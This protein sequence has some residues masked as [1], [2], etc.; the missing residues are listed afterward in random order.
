MHWSNS[1][2]II[3]RAVLS[4]Q[5]AEAHDFKTHSTLSSPIDL[6]MSN[7]HRMHLNPVLSKQESMIV[8]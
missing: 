5:S 7:E 8:I 1:T 6:E 2:S 4:P 3:Y